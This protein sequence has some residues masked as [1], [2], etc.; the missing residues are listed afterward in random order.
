MTLTGTKEDV[1]SIPVVTVSYN[2][3]EL[4]LGLLTSLRKFYPNPVYVIDGSDPEPQAKIRSIV[5]EFEGV[6]LSAFSYNIH[7]GPGLA[8]AIENLGLTGPVLFLD[9][10]I[11]VL[12]DGF[13]EALRAELREGDYGA[14]GVNYVNQDGFNIEYSYGAIPCLQ[15]PCMLCNVEVMRQ[16]PL[17]VKHGSPMIEAM[18]AL[19]RAGKSELLRHIDWTLNDILAG[20]RKVFIDHIGRGTVRATGS[21]HLDEWIAEV[22]AKQQQKTSASQAPQACNPYLLAFIPT[23]AERVIEVG[24]STGG[25]AQA[26]KATNPDCDY[27]GIEIDARA[28][29]LARRYCNKVSVLDIELLQD[30][31]LAALSDRNCWI[32]GEVLEHL[33]DP[34]HLLARIRK[35]IPAG[36]CIVACVPNAQ[37]WSVQA[38]L[39]IGHF[40]YEHGGLFDR[41]SLRWFTRVTLLEMFQQAGFRMD[42]GTPCIVDEPQRERVLPAIRALA[43]CMGGNP[44]QAATDALPI[45]YVIRFVPL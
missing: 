39:S 11:V 37:H 22:T 15:P 10:D 4:L 14:G 32:F 43:E 34:W 31:D 3:P 41:A 33:R 2:T 13:L 6:Q 35:I 29:E 45:K 19:A 23:T 30:D 28:A 20:T 44:D 42:T 40:R 27:Q 8:W 1:A 25:L 36:G 21:Y 12:R 9:S 16:W 7:H 5:S 18:L 24:C 38:K 17:P 26:F